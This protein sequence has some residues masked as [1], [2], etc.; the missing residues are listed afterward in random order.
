MVQLDQNEKNFLKICRHF[1]AM[2]DTPV[3]QN[4]EKERKKCMR[5]AV[6]YLILSPYDNEQ[7][8]LLHRMLGERALESIPTFK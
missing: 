5:S 3:I 7:S 6:L 2:L 1:R 4:D 8:D